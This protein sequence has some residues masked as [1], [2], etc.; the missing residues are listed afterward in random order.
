[1][2]KLVFLCYPRHP[3]SSKYIQIPCEDRCLEAFWKHFSGK[4]WESKH[5]SSQ[6]IWK[7]RVMW[8][9]N[10]HRLHIQGGPLQVISVG[11]DSTNGGYNQPQLAIYFRPY[12]KGP[13]PIYPVI[14]LAFRGPPCSKTP[15][16]EAKLNSMV[17]SGSPKRW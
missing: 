14:I 9:T 1:M 3:K 8:G 6:G 4:F 17:V 7:T 15:L 12:K 5:R 11:F 16:P 2:K 10:L 13:A